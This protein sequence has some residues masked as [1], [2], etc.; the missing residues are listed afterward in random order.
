MLE[1][2]SS[3]LER[4]SSQLEKLHTFFLDPEGPAWMW[5]EDPQLPFA[6]TAFPSQSP[7][8][9]IRVRS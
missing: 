2:N 3:P 1:G 7:R 5:G 4:K 8:L 6:S 9:C